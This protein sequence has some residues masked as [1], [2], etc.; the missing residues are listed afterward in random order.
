MQLLRKERRTVRKISTWALPLYVTQAWSNVSDINCEWISGLDGR[1][2]VSGQK[3]EETFYF[4]LPTSCVGILKATISST[5]FTTAVFIILRYFYRGRERRGKT[6][7]STVSRSSIHGRECM[8]CE[9]AITL[10]NFVHPLPFRM[11]RNFNLQKV[12]VGIGVRR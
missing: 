8:M 5:V 7:N 1:Q 4:Y 6:K 9:H 11:N 10:C 2:H 12:G 3:I